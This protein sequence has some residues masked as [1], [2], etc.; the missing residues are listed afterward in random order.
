VYSEK[1]DVHI[2]ERPSGNSRAAFLRRLRTHRPDIHKRVLAGE[3]SPHAGMVEAG[4]R[5]K[6]VR[7][8]R[9][10]LERVHRNIRR[11]HD[12][13]LADAI[14]HGVVWK[15]MMPLIA[16]MCGQAEDRRKLW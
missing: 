10:R 14:P 12:H 1:G 2:S 13:H 9:T 8:K 4:F 5:K 15:R 11:L 7:K 16:P 6:P 3:L